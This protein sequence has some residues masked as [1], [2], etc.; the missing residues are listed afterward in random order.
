MATKNITTN[1]AINA[2]TFLAGA[3]KD[4]AKITINGELIKDLG[5]TV[6]ADNTT[7]IIPGYGSL[8][9]VGAGQVLKFTASSSF[10]AGDFKFV[11]ANGATFTEVDL[12]SATNAVTVTAS[13]AT[14]KVTGGAGNDSITG[15]AATAEIVG[16][17]G[18]DTI[19]T[20][21]AGSP[22]N[23]TGGTGADK[24][25]KVRRLEIWL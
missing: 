20:S 6:S 16:G 3:D 21:L 7:I 23:V 4:V 24:F 1:A 10:P 19:T 2:G 9:H 25:V 17:A 15:A 18:N 22:S 12:S 13:A 5:A 11:D 8:T 14:T